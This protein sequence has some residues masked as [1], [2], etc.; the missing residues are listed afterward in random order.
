[1]N[2]RCIVHNRNQ[3]KRGDDYCEMKKMLYTDEKKFTGIDLQKLA[4]NNTM[5][6]NAK[7]NSENLEN[8]YDDSFTFMDGKVTENCVLSNVWRKYGERRRKDLLDNDKK[9]GGTTFNLSKRCSIKRYF[10]LSERVM[11]QFNTSFE[12]DKDIENTF[13][14]GNRLLSFLTEAL[15]Q[16]P[17]YMHAV[18]LKQRE[19]SIGGLVQVKKRIEELSHRIDEDQLNHYIANDF[20]PIP[21]D[22]DSSSAS[23]AEITDIANSFSTFGSG[24]SFK[25]TAF[26]SGGFISEAIWEDFSGWSNDMERDDKIIFN[27]GAADTE[28]DVTDEHSRNIQLVEV[29]DKTSPIVLD[30]IVSTQP[31]SVIIEGIC[32]DF[33]TRIA[34]EEVIYETDSEAADS[35]APDEEEDTR[36]HL[37][38]DSI[39]SSG[40][41]KNSGRIVFRELMNRSPSPRTILVDILTKDKGNESEMLI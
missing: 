35:W 29:E 10:E 36:S 39:R 2:G 8:L 11:D 19:K 37:S 4:V 15:P 17:S 27:N 5:K 22:D 41:A 32:T 38:F 6:G 23:T 16:H 3:N 12:N 14:M 24:E 20:D 34:K 13:I 7:L 28:E 25:E 40:S 18:V 21:D 9:E 26:E 30:R 1:M 33:L 31:E